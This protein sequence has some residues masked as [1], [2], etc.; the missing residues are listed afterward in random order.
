[1][2]PS[3][4]QLKEIEIFVQGINWFYFLVGLSQGHVIGIVLKVQGQG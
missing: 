1:M 2:L 4:L 3:F